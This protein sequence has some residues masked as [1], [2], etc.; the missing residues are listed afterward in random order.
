[1]DVETARG[2]N[3]PDDFDQA[4][5]RANINDYKAENLN[6]V[7]RGQLILKTDMKEEKEKGEDKKGKMKIEINHRKKINFIKQNRES[8]R[9]KQKMLSPIIKNKNVSL[10]KHLIIEKE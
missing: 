4:Q 8:I 5:L 6:S 3:A 10:P 9:N 2:P 7:I 1:M